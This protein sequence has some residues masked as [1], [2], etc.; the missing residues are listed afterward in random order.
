MNAGRENPAGDGRVC[1]VGGILIVIFDC[2]VG[3]RGKKDRGED[4]HGGGDP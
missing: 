4:M 2:C 3:L 1:F